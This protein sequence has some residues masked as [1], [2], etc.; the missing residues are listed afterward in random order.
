MKRT[1]NILCTALASILMLSSCGGADI[2][3]ADLSQTPTAVV[4]EAQE[5]VA[6][7]PKLP[8][9]KETD[10]PADT[11]D[12]PAE[13]KPVLPKM[14][15]RLSDI[16]VTN[17]IPEETKVR[18]AK[19]P[20]ADYQH[21]PDWNGT[22]LAGFSINT[23]GEYA[24][25]FTEDYIK[26]VSDQGFNFVRVCL[27]TRGFFAEP[28][29]PVRAD[30]SMINTRVIQVIDDLIRLCIENDIHVCLDVHN[31]FGGLM[32]GGDEETSRE[33]LFTEGSK[34]EQ[35]LFDF[36]EFMAMRY[37]DIPSNALSFNIYNEPPAFVTDEQYTVFIKKALDVIEKADPD[38]LIFVDM[39]N[40]AHDPVQGLVGEKVVQAFHFYEPHRF[41]HSHYTDDNSFA[42]AYAKELEL[43]PEDQSYPLPAVNLG[44]TADDYVV[45]GDFPAGTRLVMRFG[46]GSVDSGAKLLAD[47]NEIFSQIF[48]RELLESRRYTINGDNVFAYYDEENEGL[49]MIEFTTELPEAAKELRFVLTDKSGWLDLNEFVVETDTYGTMLQGEWI[50]GVGDALP[51]TRAVIDENGHV[52][53]TNDADRY[54]YGKDDIEEQFRIYKDFSEATGTAVM[55]METGDIV[56]NNISDT[57]RYYDDVL[58]LCDEFGFNWVHYSYDYVDFSYAYKWDIYK[59]HGATYT[60]LGNGRYVCN[61]LREVFQRHM[62]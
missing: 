14:T 24:N 43:H 49:P 26:E 23:S 32:M 9:D 15:E 56:Y 58:S 12:E 62:K 18:A 17:T 27:D 46:E 13:S 36:W 57:V 30:S 25:I 61:E 19:M 44:I 37:S 41:T 42:E 35:I 16:A 50:E 53:L 8:E 28:G 5:T 1:I 4:T 2:G 3:E 60:D 39:L 38:R 40:Y 51:P 29:K 55:L 47:G 33:Q 22:T 48:D 10:D 52:T 59:R 31:S 34:E 6:P 45:T 21:L 54:T 20:E 7:N 11:V